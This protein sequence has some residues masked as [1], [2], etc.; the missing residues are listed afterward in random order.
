MKQLLLLFTFCS[1][2]TG[3]NAQVIDISGVLIIKLITGDQPEML[4]WEFTDEAGEVVYFGGNHLVESDGTGTMTYPKP[5][6]PYNHVIDFP[7]NGNY[8]FRAFTKPGTNSGG[9]SVK[10]NNSNAVTVSELKDFNGEAI[11]KFR[12]TNTPNFENAG[13]VSNMD[14]PPS[15]SDCQGKKFKPAFEIKNTGTNNITSGKVDFSLDGSVM[16][17]IDWTG[18]IAPIGTATITFDEIDLAGPVELRCR[19]LELNGTSDFGQYQGFLKKEFSG[20][21]E[22]KSQKTTLEFKTDGNGHEIYWEFKGPDGNVLA[23]GGN[24]K[25]GSGTAA[26]GDPGAYGNQ[27]T[28]SAVLTG[29]P[30]GGGCY[31]LT[32]KDDGGDGFVRRTGSTL[33]DETGNVA[34]LSDFRVGSE[35]SFAVDFDYEPVSAGLGDTLSYS[36]IHNDSLR[37]YLLYVPAA[38][39]GTDEW[40]LVISYHEYSWPAAAHMALTGM[41]AVA[42]S[43]HFIVAYP[44]GLK[45]LNPV[46]NQEGSGWNETGSL[47]QNNDVDF[48][49]ALISKISAAYNI[50][51]AAVYATGFGMGGGMV[52]MLLCNLPDK[53]AS[54]APVCTPLTDLQLMTCMPDR[55]VSYMFMVGTEDPFIPFNPD[56]QHPVVTKGLQGSVDFWTTNNNCSPDSTIFELDDVDANDNSTVTLIEFT[57]CDAETEVVIY[58]INDGGHTWPGG[59]PVPPFFGIGNHDINASEEV[60]Q[61]FKRNRHPSLVSIKEKSMLLS[62]PL[63]YPNPAVDQIFIDLNMHSPTSCR[64]KLKTLLGRTLLE[65][66][67]KHGGNKDLNLLFSIAGKNINAGLYIVEL[68]LENGEVL[69]KP[70]VLLK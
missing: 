66:K 22:Q 32:F 69:S 57:D 62:E 46:I 68:V 64:V 35:M 65:Q 28:I 63:I 16:Q 9:A 54:V 27:E 10:L 29:D 24:P 44:Q 39:D 41:N 18:N 8:E 45:V 55:P 56:P 31:S 61:F 6:A 26:P 7:E 12:V 67:Y 14:S 70:I 48:T 59:G 4:G 58:R 51:P 37:S 43:G 60:W 13:F 1:F 20:F 49:D 33:T 42:D 2:L 21:Y 23:S 47:S 25:A 17:E 15:A 52:N 34:E 50:D 11:V 53:I 40:P 36:F 3:T 5:N 38:Y 30:N 19:I